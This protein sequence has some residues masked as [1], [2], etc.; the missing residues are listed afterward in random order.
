MQYVTLVNRSS[1]PVEGVWDG[2]ATII[3][4]GES[5]HP[6]AEARAFQQQHPVMGSYDPYS[7]H[8]D[9]LLASEDFGDSDF[10]P[11]EQTDAKELLARRP[12]EVA[13]ER[14][15]TMPIIERHASQKA[16]IIATPAG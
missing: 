11:I 9:Y 15:R 7:G 16:D 12:G 13:Y 4:P 5:Q 8:C 10:E 6:M 1:K 14:V 3:P 2:K